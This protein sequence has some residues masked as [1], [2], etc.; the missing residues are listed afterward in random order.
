MGALL[1][2]TNMENWAKFDILTVN[3][4]E[5]GKF[6]HLHSWLAG[7]IRAQTISS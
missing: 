6:K 5:A 7:S 3:S 4:H 2:G 1:Q